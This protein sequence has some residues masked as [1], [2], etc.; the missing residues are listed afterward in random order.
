M[1]KVVARIR[2]LQF[3][4]IMNSLGIGRFFFLVFLYFFFSAATYTYSRTVDGSYLLSAIYLSVIFAIHFK[5]DDHIFLKSQVKSY[6]LVYFQE[7]TAIALPLIVSNVI[8]GHQSNIIILV[9]TLVLTPFVSVKKP[10]YTINTSI[11]KWIPPTLYEW[12]SGVRTT[13]FYLS[14]TWIS[15]LATSFWIGSVP[16][17]IIIIG[18]IVTNFNS[19]ME[20]LAMLLS[21]ESSAK[22][23]LCKKVL[24]NL[25]VYS[26]IVI[27]LVGAFLI[28]HSS[29]WYIVLIL[30]ALSSLIV[31]YSILVKYAFYEPSENVTANQSIVTLGAT[32]II[33]PALLPVT[34]ILLIRFYFKAIKN[35]NF[36]LNDYN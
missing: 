34:I 14:I 6:R 22:N 7:Y 12:K 29:Y 26:I 19:K 11:Q 8:H 18:L 33:L 9:V 21:F 13:F 28:Q 4:R 1:T 36:Y 16:I 10:G 25:Q 30:Y 27:P 20:S 23:L 35:L 31:V 17:A 32:S 24:Q 15:S 5:R 3:A 2:L